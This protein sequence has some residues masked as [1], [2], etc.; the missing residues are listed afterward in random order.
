GM[1][2]KQIYQIIKSQ[3]DNNLLDQKIV[4]LLFDNFDTIY[5]H[6]KEKQAAA[7]HFYDETV[8]CA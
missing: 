7:R 3:A 8:G 1:N 5:S 2:K 4:D 6:V